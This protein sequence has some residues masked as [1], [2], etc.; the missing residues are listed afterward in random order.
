MKRRSATRD[1]D[2]VTGPDVS[3][4]SAFELLGSRAHAQPPGAIDVRNH[5][6]VLIRDDNIGQRHI[7]V[8]HGV[9]LPTEVAPPAPAATRVESRRDL[10]AFVPAAVI[11]LLWLVWVGSSGGY[12][13]ETWYPSAFVVFSLWVAV[14]AFGRQVLPKSRAARAG[15]LAFA[16][17][18]ALNYLSIAWATAKGSA[19]GASNQLALYLLVAW[20]FA[21]LPWTPRALVAALG[22][23]SLGVCVFCAVALIDATSAHTLTSFFINGRFSTP[24]QYSN[25]TGALGVMAMWPALILSSRRELPFWLRGCFLGVAAFLAGFATL[26]QSR[27]AL[28]GLILTGPVALL[29]ASDRARLAARMAVV[30]GTLAVCLP[31]TVSVDNAVNANGNVSPVLSHAAVAMLVCAIAALLLGIVFSLAED[32]WAAPLARRRE[33]WRAARGRSGPSPRT[34]RRGAAVVALVVV[35]AGGVAA[36]PGVV[37][38]VHSVIRNGN[39]DASTST[40]STRLLSA[41]PEERFDYVRVALHLFAGDPVLGIGSGNFGRRYDALRRFVK[42]SQYTHNLPL[43]V[44]SETGLVGA[45]IF[46]VLVVALLAG[47][48][49]ATRRR[50]DLGRAGAVIAMC[51]SGYFLVHSCLDWVDEFPALAAPAIA[52]PLAAIAAAWRPDAAPGAARGSR[53]PRALRTPVARRVAGA[54]GVL[55]AV[56][57]LVALTASYVSLRLVDRAFATFRSNPG[58]AYSN[59]STAQSINPLDVNPI[60]S[61]GTIALYLGDTGRASR[62]FERAVRR[63]DDWYPRVELA[64]IDAQ[65][66]RFDAAVRQMDAAIRMDAD[67]PIVDQARADIAAHH[68]LNPFT[69]N[70]QILNEGNVTS[71]V[72]STVR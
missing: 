56:V 21:V 48:V 61:E 19:L 23:W 6:D 50:N 43:R 3:G 20:I 11:V 34:V 38:V 60:T 30:G 35:V 39:S 10:R 28:L 71:A 42:H 22:T 67:D 46:V 9:T 64:L 68:R 54:A 44:L 55:A 5:P 47:L 37:H 24:M 26:P 1:G 33:R 57:V 40:G 12:A 16:A 15:L 2:G 8:G 66:G 36:A 29:A 53:V 13:A 59:L 17:L 32:R 25:A 41:S 51:V 7:P 62:A 72:Q 27:A 70:S 58:Q 65:A 52:I 45:L 69:V 63:Q 49:A 14:L 18:V 31:R 4:Q